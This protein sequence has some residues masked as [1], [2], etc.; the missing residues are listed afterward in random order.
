MDNKGVNENNNQAIPGVKV[1]PP[2]EELVET[3]VDIQLR[4]PVEKNE[5]K[6]KNEAVAPPEILS[7]EKVLTEEEKKK[8]QENDVHVIEE[9]VKKNEKKKQVKITGF[10]LFIIFLLV[11]VGGLMF[12]TYSLKIK[13]FEEI[14]SP[15]S[16]TKGSKELDLDSLIVK[17]LYSKV[18]TDIFEDLGQ[19]E[20]NDELKLYLAYRQIGQGEVYSSNCNLFNSAN[21]PAFTCSVNDFW[22][23]KAFKVETLE[24]EYK[25]LFG[26][27]SIFPKRNIQLGNSCLGGYQ[28]IESRGEYVEGK[29]KTTGVSMYSA[30]KKLIGATSRESTIVLKESVKYYGNVENKLPDGFISGTY[31]YTFKLDRNYNYVFVSK[32]LVK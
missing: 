23:P 13:E 9:K 30:D 24:K 10:L 15:V 26:E 20:L 4:E 11:A 8:I 6:V 27:N 3:L 21:M 19:I 28:Y 14:S 31:E 5:K 29:C 1:A 32:Q 16:T 2:K 12:Y 7:S 17:D 18:S 22:A 25:K